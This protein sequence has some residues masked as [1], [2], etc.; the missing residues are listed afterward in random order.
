[1][2]LVLKLGLSIYVIMV[3]GFSAFSEATSNFTENFLKP[4]QSQLHLEMT[5]V[6]EEDVSGNLYFFT[7]SG[8]AFLVSPQCYTNFSAQNLELPQEAEISGFLIGTHNSLNQN[9]ETNSPGVLFIFDVK[10]L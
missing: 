6:F 3:L 5:G 9:F 8:G 2:R 4:T 1:M 7:N 10:K